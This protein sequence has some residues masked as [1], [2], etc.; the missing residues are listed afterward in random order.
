MIDL[1]RE[2]R[3][4]LWQALTPLQQE[5]LQSVKKYQMQSF[6]LTENLLKD[7][8]WF[9]VDFRENPHYPDGVE[10][11]KLY[12][13]CGRELKYQFVLVSK[14]TGEKLALG[15]THFAQHTGIDPKVAQ[16]VQAGVHQ[17]DRGIDLILLGIDRGLSF[18]SVIIVILSIAG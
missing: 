6:F 3:R 9:F 7:D 16:Q 17:L 5:T 14:N 10:K 1:T 18:Q 11:S 12:C 15:S 8:E 4:T 13:R 2:Q